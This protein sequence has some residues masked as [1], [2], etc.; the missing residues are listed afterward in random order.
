MTSH[1]V[2][3]RPGSRDT[4]LT[5]PD[6]LLFSDG[7][8][9]GNQKGDFQGG[10]AVTTLDDLLESGNLP[11]AESANRQSFTPSPEHTSSQK[12][13]LSMFILTASV[14]LGSHIIWGCYGSKGIFFHLLG[15][16]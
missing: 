4:P 15:L 9:R 1:F 16:Q 11:P 10:Y 2:T 13:K 3:P 6:L 14:P 5:N 8:Y 7:P 12:D